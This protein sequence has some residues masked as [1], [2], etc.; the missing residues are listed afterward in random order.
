MA[1]GF[2]PTRLSGEPG[3]NVQPEVS[4]RQ[5]RRWKSPRRLGHRDSIQSDD[6]IGHV[7]WASSRLGPRGARI[8][9]KRRAHSVR[10]DVQLSR[11]PT[12]QG[13]EPTHSDTTD[14]SAVTAWITAEKFR[15]RGMKTRIWLTIIVISIVWIQKSMKFGPRSDCTPTRG[16]GGMAM[17]GLSVRIRGRGVRGR[18]ANARFCNRATTDDSYNAASRWNGA[19]V[20]KPC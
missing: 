12:R 20:T 8:S 6:T 17:G 2:R 19:S 13:G 9:S 16:K 11:T 7:H 14:T 15:A 3:A 4:F 10:C 5:S 1:R 18:V